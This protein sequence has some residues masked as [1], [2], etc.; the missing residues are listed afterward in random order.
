[1]IFANLKKVLKKKNSSKAKYQVRAIC[2][3]IFLGLIKARDKD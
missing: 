3:L 1:M 2:V